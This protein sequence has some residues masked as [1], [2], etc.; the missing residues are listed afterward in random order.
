MAE[1]ICAECGESYWAISG[2]SR[3][4]AECISITLNCEEC[5]QPFEQRRATRQRHRARFCSRTC[6]GAGKGHAQLNPRRGPANNRYNGGLCFDRAK[7][8]WVICCTDGTLMAFYRGV[9][10]AELGRPLRSD[11]IVHHINGDSSDDRIENLM[12]VTRS[13]HM[14]MHHPEIMAARNG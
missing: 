3:Y 7:R 12:L 10:E 5:G 1:Y 2:K 13:E 8:R 6:A 14:K 4:C 11:E 9:M